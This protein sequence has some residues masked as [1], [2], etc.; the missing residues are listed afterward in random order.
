MGLKLVLEKSKNLK[1]LK[2]TT[3]TK[4]QKRDGALGLKP[5]VVLNSTCFHIAR[6]GWQP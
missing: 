3:E 5:P 4:K 6:A 2:L 1:N